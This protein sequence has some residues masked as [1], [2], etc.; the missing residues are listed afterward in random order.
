MRHRRA[1]VVVIAAL[2]VAAGAVTVTWRWLG[3]ERRLGGVVGRLLA[4]RT[5]LPI[6]VG[7]AHAGGGHVTLHDVRL[8]SHPF[9]IRVSRLDVT[10]GVVSLLASAGGPV[11]IVA[12]SA[13]VVV[14]EGGIVPPLD[15]LRA[16]VLSLLDWPGT[17]RLTMLGGELESKGRRFVFDL[18]GEKTQDGDVV[19]ALAVGPVAE[20]AALKV[21]A[22]A[23]VGRAG[24]VQLAVEL[25]GEPRRLAGLWP[26]TLP[27]PTTLA[28]RGDVIVVKGGDAEARGRLTVGASAAPAVVDGTVRYDARTG[29]VT[30]PRYVLTRADGVHLEGAGALEPG[31]EGRRI[32]ARAAG[33]I[34]GARVEGRVRYEVST[35]VFDGEASVRGGT[36]RSLWKR[37]DLPGAP[38]EEASV[39]TVSARFSGVDRAAGVTMDVDA[40]AGGVRLAR[41]PAL[42]VDATVNA[43]VRV[44]PDARGLRLASISGATVSVTRAG[45]PLAVITGASRGSALWPL[46]V[47]ARVADA[48]RLAPWLPF[49]PAL[50]GSARLTG[51]LEPGAFAGDLVADLAS[52]T[53]MLG[54]PVTLTNVRAAVPVRWQA[55]AASAAGSVHVERAAGYGFVA[56]EISSPATL[57][58][59]RLVLADVR[60]THYGG[61]GAGTLEASTHAPLRFAARVVGDSVDLA[62]FVREAGV[63]IARATGRVDYVMSIQQTAAHGLFLAGRVDGEA[64]GGEIG[65]DA[66]E[67]LLASSTTDVDGSGLL[68]RTLENLKIFRYDSLAADVRLTGATGHIDVALKGRKRLG[69]FPGPVDAINLHHVPLDVLART[70]AK[71]W[72][73]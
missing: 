61:R 8:D 33:T 58:D 49:Q 11:E 63:T 27:P 64:G 60:Y 57:T 62:A 32:V 39:A 6:T 25:A 55:P 5:G 56:A 46:S 7:A 66:I 20:R 1:L 52:A 19:M 47:D 65:I 70:F 42:P 50:A 15:V 69:I 23:T 41:W 36:V 34:D 73:P 31:R 44:A 40:V 14:A 59:G 16:H 53:V 22:R 3:E 35:G 67:R 26:A 29:V 24:A 72:S 4:H 2:L 17:M 9:D 18:T 54:A 37:L 43:A 28:S 68:R 38:P 10:G 45:L 30:A 51:L 12:T 71:G 13:S 48:G 21:S